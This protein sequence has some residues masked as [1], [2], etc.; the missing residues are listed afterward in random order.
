M[1]EAALSWPLNNGKIHY[2]LSIPAAYLER[3]KMEMTN[4]PV[5]YDDGLNALAYLYDVLKDYAFGMAEEV[6]D[7]EKK[8]RY[9]PKPPV[10]TWMSV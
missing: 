7:Q 1:I 10:R 5:W 4:F 8:D 3:L 6:A 9:K 2:S